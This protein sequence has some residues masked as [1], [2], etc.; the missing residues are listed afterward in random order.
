M[1]TK[2]GVELLDFGLAKLKADDGVVSPLSQM[3]TPCFYKY[4]LLFRCGEHLG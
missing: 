2:S 3:P 4:R 1:I